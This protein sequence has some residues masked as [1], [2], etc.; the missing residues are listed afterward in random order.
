MGALRCNT[1]VPFRRSSPRWSCHTLSRRGGQGRNRS[2]Q[3]LPLP[4]EAFGPSSTRPLPDD[5]PEEAVPAPLSSSGALTGVEQVT[6]DARGPTCATTACRRTQIP[7]RPL[8]A[9]FVVEVTDS[10]EDDVPEPCS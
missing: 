10:G 4:V 7:E 5:L 8:L 9:P 3:R 6:D 2:G 1:G